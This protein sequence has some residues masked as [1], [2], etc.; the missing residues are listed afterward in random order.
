MTDKILISMKEDDVE[1]KMLTH[2]G[3]NVKDQRHAAYLL[4]VLAGHFE[5][6]FNEPGEEILERALRCYRQDDMNPDSIQ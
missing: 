5:Q 6:I 2:I 4:A 3:Q 1:D